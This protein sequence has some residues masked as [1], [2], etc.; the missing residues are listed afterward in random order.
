MSIYEFPK[1][2]RPLSF[3]RVYVK[4]LSEMIYQMHKNTQSKAGLQQEILA[5]K[6]VPVNMTMNGRV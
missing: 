2:I 6:M 1:V 3:I 5:L 4:S